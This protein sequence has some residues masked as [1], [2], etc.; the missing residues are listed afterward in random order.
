MFRLAGERK[1]RVQS[2]LRPPS[3]AG[4]KPCSA[5]CRTARSPSRA[6]AQFT[7]PSAAKGGQSGILNVNRSDHYLPGDAPTVAGPAR[8]NV[9]S[10]VPVPAD[11]V[12]TMYF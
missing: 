7:T 11:G 3:F 10:E 5:I 12:G 9:T 8:L 6:S 2:L 1:S 4:P